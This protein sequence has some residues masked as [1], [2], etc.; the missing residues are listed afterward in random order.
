MKINKINLKARKLIQMMSNW[1]VSVYIKQ[2][3]INILILLILYYMHHSQ[4]SIKIFN[5]KIDKYF[6]KKEYN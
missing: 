5:D 2:L 3:I 4:S 6:K 1:K